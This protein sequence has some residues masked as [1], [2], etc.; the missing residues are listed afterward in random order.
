M[1]LENSNRAS[2]A[3]IAFVV[4]IVLFVALGLTVKLAMT[5]PSIDED[6]GAERSKALAQLRA[7]ED[8]SLNTAGWIDQQRGIV[9]LPI[10][11]AIQQAAGQNAELIRNDL[12]IR[13]EKAA[14]PAPV[15]PAKPSAFE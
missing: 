6:R 3:A 13:A 1:T 9:R 2:G 14:A 15:A 10:E 11:T 4:A 12:K 7:T 8:K 5:S